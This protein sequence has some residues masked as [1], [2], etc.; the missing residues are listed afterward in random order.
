[1][2]RLILARMYGKRHAD[3]TLG[4][5][6]ETFEC[7]KADL[8]GYKREL[9][10]SFRGER[11]LSQLKYGG[12]RSSGCS[13]SGHRIKQGRCTPSTPARGGDCGSDPVEVRLDP[14]GDLEIQ[15]TARLPVRAGGPETSDQV[16]TASTACTSPRAPV[17]C[18]QS[19]SQLQNKERAFGDP[20][21]PACL[22]RELADSATQRRVPPVGPGVGRVNRSEKMRTLQTVKDNRITD[23]R[24]HRIFSWSRF[25]GGIR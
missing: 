6:R 3:Q 2:G 11:G 23:H 1:V 21:G 18:T 5:E 22:E 9:I 15:P 10:L 14:S 13:G 7:L 8:G 12:R 4:L 17:F 24:L 25:P 16:E 20:C 19:R